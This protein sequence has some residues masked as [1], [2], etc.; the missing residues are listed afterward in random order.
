M[1]RF[2]KN[3]LK[4]GMVIAGMLLFMFLFIKIPMSAV[5]AH[6]SIEEAA[7]PT[8]KATP[9]IDATMAALTKEQLQ[10]I[11]ELLPLPLLRTVQEGFP[12]YGYSVYGR[13]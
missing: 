7:T 4:A 6:G 12:S 5:N 2:T 1:R 8:A 13:L 10:S 9:T 11:R 3:I